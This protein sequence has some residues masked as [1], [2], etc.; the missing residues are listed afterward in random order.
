MTVLFNKHKL[1]KNECTI[2]DFSFLLYK[3]GIRGVPAAP[4]LTSPVPP[5]SG[6]RVYLSSKGGVLRLKT[7]SPVGLKFGEMVSVT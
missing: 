5:A 7:Q 4:A 3:M 6:T 1:G 2:Y